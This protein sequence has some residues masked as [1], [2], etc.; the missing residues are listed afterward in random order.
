MKTVKSVLDIADL[1]ICI[2]RRVQWKITA[3]YR[4]VAAASQM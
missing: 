2:V 1:C 4:K 3:G